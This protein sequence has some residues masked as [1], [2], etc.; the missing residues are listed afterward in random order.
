MAG[1]P[2]FAVVGQNDHPLFEDWF[3]PRYAEGAE[4]QGDAEDLRYLH[5]FIVHKAIDKVSEIQWETEKMNLK[6]V[7]GDYEWSV[8][9]FVTAGQVKIMLLHDNAITNNEGGIKNF[10][11]EIHEL[12]V[13]S[14]LNPFYIPGKPIKSTNFR[15]KVRSL[16]KKYL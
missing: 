4:G 12:Y 9:S 7:D 5:Q 16:A 15:A 3:D 2:Y 13:K 11:G 8:S 14:L 6:V 10:F 1:Y